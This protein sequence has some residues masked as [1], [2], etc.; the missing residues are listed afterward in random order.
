MIK[1]SNEFIESNEYIKRIKEFWKNPKKRKK[2]LWTIGIFI[3]LYLIYSYF[4][5]S[6]TISK[7]HSDL[8][9]DKVRKKPINLSKKDSFSML[10][11][12][13]DTGAIGRSGGGRADSIIIV[14][15]NAKENKTT[16]VSIPRDTYTK[17]AKKNKTT[18]INEAYSYGGAATVINTVQKKFGIPIDYYIEVNMKG[19]QDVV[20]AVGGV[21]V[22]SSMSFSNYGYTFKKGR[23]KLDGKKALAY[24][25]MRHED[26]TGDYGRQGRQRQIINELVGK[27]VSFKTITNQGKLLKSMEKNIRTNLEFEEIVTIQGKYNKA[28]R[29]IEQVQ[30]KGQGDMINGISY[31]I[32]SQKEISKITKLLKE[33]L[34]LN[35]IFK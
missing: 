2:T 34:H 20:N 19:V 6:S 13:V 25:T 18:K 5:I 10:L 11:L 23:N 1:K 12:G 30:I 8:K 33:E 26:P 9:V 35:G 29:N 15:V 14:T 17:I 4:G 21:T 16:L 28:L 22:K 32:I 24:A 7:I 31:Q 3:V 27:I